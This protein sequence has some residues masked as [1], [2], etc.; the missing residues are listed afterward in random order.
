VK[1]MLRRRPSPAL[2]ISLI[3]LFLSLGGVSYGL[4]T[5]SIDSR[6]IKNNDVRSRDLRNNQIR[7][8]DVRNNEMRGI[9]IRNSTVQD[10]DVALN[11]LGGDDIN[12]SRLGKVPSAAAADTAT[13]ASTATSATTAG[14]V[15]GVRLQ[16][17]AYSAA[18]GGAF[19]TV[20]DLGGLRLE[21]RC[22]T[23]PEL[24]V[25]ANPAGTL[26]NSE[27]FSTFRTPTPPPSSDPDFDPGANFAVVPPGTTSADAV[28]TIA[29]AGSDGAVVTVS[30]HVLEQDNGIRGS[31]TDDC[32]FFG[33][34]EAG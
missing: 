29:F 2:V 9:D 12:E 3:A 4:A 30:A 15:G 21:A 8:R 27:I 14:S 28:G 20:L 17:I 7:T 26:Q 13:S 5:G 19:T 16:K 23:G 1:S 18:T 10:R 6:E 11:T 31:T 24:E 25:R 32:G 22:L 33:I 34:A